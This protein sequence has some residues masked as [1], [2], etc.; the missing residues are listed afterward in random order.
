MLQ[1]DAHLTR[2]NNSISINFLDVVKL[3][4]NLATQDAKKIVMAMLNSGYGI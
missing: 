3:R 4:L 1:C 2:P